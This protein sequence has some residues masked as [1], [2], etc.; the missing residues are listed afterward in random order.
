MEHSTFETPFD[1]V[2][3]AKIMDNLNKQKGK[4]LKQSRVFPKS[5][6]MD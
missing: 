4:T 5:Y 1:Y 6:D 3:D 2:H